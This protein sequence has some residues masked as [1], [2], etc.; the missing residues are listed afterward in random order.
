MR[1][2]ALGAGTGGLALATAGQAAPTVSAAI[3][4]GLGVLIA[5]AVVPERIRDGR[6]ESTPS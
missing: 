1:G 5:T 4:G 3:I 6:D 2:S